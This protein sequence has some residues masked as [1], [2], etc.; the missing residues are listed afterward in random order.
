MRVVVDNGPGNGR[1]T[2][3]R[4]IRPAAPVTTLRAAVAADAPALHALIAAHLEEGR[5]LPR[6]MSELAAHAP[7]FVV[8]VQGDRIVG[9][10]ELAPLSAAVAEVRSLVVAGEARQTGLG[11]RIVDEL[12]RR[13]RR[14]GFTQLCAFAH[15]PRFFVRLG[16][17]IVP[18]TWVPEKIARDCHSC[19]LFR[20]CGQYAVVLDVTR[21]QATSGVATRATGSSH[22]G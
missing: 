5:L 4:R 20:N 22:R 13:A 18:H 16:F 19:P 3:A 17:S 1:R 10:A 7:R 11:F 2:A 21:A 8:A 14:E 6:T 15:D 12:G 9:C